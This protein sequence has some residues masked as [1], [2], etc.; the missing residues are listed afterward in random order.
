VPEPAYRKYLAKYAEPEACFAAQLRQRYGAAL[1]VPA[2]A[3][4]ASFVADLEP[5]LNAASERVLLIVVVNATEGSEPAVHAAN[6][7][8]L[9]ALP[10]PLLLRQ[11]LTAGVGG[12]ATAVLGRAG[13]YDLLLIDRASP[14]RRLPLD[15]GVGLARRI[16][17]DV[18]LALYAGGGLA[19][20]WL[21]CTDGDARL[22]RDY[23]QQNALTSPRGA[24]G[25]RRV[26]LTVPFLHVPGG[27]AEV[28]HATALYEL[29]LR[30]YT[31]GLAS[32]GSAYAYES[33]G[34][35][36]VTLAEAYA[37][38]R[39]FPRRQAGEDFYL[40]DKLAKVGSVHRPEREPILLR[41]RTSARV[42]FGTGARV[43][44]ILAD[45]G[46]LT[47]YH[48]RVFELLGLTLT[49]LRRAVVAQREDVVALELSRT[50]DAGSSGAVASALDELQAL[51]A[52][53]EM[54]SASPTPIVRIR[55]L[56]TWFDALR[57]L[58]FIHLVEARAGLGRRPVLEAVASAGF[59]RFWR[60]E[61]TENS[62]R[63]AAFSAEQALPSDVGVENAILNPVNAEPEHNASEQK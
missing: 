13:H 28:D 16:G 33:L 9:E 63:I 50:L 60:P 44:E 55:R 31:L 45:D 24:G 30:Y 34:S 61:M 53:R 29:S 52:L 27:H 11:E 4:H 35:T 5:A 7:Q 59:C 2:Y 6:Q 25:V 48:P 21:G 17:L 15:Q 38:V 22:P 41:S 43:S 36:I 47:T 14:G 58:R 18:A 3:E 19:S 37:E 40:L 49:A 56:L 57:T 39:G 42:P 8:L 10:A 62:V 51:E 26:A 1:V 32:A 23:F 20:A 46:G 54:F 12:N